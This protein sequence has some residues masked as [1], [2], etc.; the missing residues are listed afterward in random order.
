MKTNNNEIDLLIEDYQ[1]KVKT[2]KNANGSN[3]VVETLIQTKLDSYQTFI[4]ELEKL[5]NPLNV[6]EESTK[7]DD[8]KYLILSGEGNYETEHQ[9]CMEVDNLEDANEY[10]D[11]FKK[12]TYKEIN[13]YIYKGKMIRN[14]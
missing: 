2:L 10:F 8:N 6:E 5:K 7:N 9:F 1:R 3:I 4:I 13:L 11:D 14:E 12:N